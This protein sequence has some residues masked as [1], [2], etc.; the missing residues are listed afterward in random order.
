M[1]RNERATIEYLGAFL[2]PGNVFVDVGAH[3][4]YFA[5]YAGRLVGCSG[6]VFAFEPFPKN[7]KLLS[8]NCRHMPQI[9][10]I[11]AAV[12]DSNGQA[13]LFEHSTSSSSHALTDISNSGKSI[14]VRKISLDDW[15]Q[16]SK[17]SRIDMALIDVEGHESS[18]LRGMREIIAGNSNITI[19]LEYCPSHFRYKDGGIHNLLEEIQKFQLYATRAFGQAREYAIPEYTSE[20][21]LENCLDGIL[22]DEI[23]DEGCDY[24]NIV[25]RRR[26]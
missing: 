11:Q 24:V 4:G 7:F 17:V 15:A 20:T 21:D 1:R 13:V 9:K 6:R 3:V 8:H 26:T 10:T 14:S 12:S 22:A 25:V 5:A 19:I 16:A 23:N 18:V 2:K